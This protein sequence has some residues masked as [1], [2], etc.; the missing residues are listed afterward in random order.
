MYKNMQIEKNKIRIWFTHADNGLMSKG[1]LTEFYIAGADKNFVSAEAKIEGN[2][3]VVWNKNISQPIAVRY[4]F[5]NGAVLNLY[6]KGGVPVN[7]FRTDDWP[8]EIV[9]NK[10]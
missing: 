7:L 6:N 2:S 1:P 3:I 8:I 9:I 10:K 4:G 5:R